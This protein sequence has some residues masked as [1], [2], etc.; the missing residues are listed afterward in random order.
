MVKSRILPS[1]IPEDLLVNKSCIKGKITNKAFTTKEYKAK[2]C[3]ELV[4][5]NMRGPFNV[6]AWEK[7]EY[8]ITFMDDYSRFGY[9]YLI[10]T[11]KIRLILIRKTPQRN[12]ELFLKI[13]F[14][15]NNFKQNKAKM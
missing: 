5:T 14:K 3:L 8:F 9:V 1:L 4:H 2:D 13:F 10:H 7:Y 15:Y 12:G 11:E 6:Y